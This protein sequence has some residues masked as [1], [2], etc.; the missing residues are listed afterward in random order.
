MWENQIQKI[1]L[2]YKNDSQQEQ[3]N[4]PENRQHRF[5]F[6]LSLDAM[7]PVQVDG[8]FRAQ[9]LDLIVRA[10]EPFSQPM[11]TEMRRLYAGALGK[12]GVTGDLSFQNRPDQWVTIT[13][14]SGQFGIST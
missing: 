3:N 6:D 13:P 10:K 12:T 9:R 14:E 11:Q 5:I 2:Y 7:G 1:A 8:L 4:N